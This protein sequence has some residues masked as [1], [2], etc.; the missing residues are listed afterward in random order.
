MKPCE[1]RKKPLNLVGWLGWILITAA[2]IC[3]HAG[4]IECDDP[5]QGALRAILSGTGDS[6]PVLLDLPLDHTSVTA[7]VTGFLARVDVTQLFT[8]NRNET[9]EAVYVFP[10]PDMAAVDA[11]TMIIGDQTIRGI[12]KKRDEAQALYEQAR[13]DGRT[14][15][16]LTQ[17]RPNIFTQAV[18]NILPGDRIEVRISYVQDLQY[19]HGE[20]EFNF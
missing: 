3:G 1:T 9:L 16:L 15:A 19:D 14:A 17:E 18:A 5:G 13:V 8:N 12:I 6:D 2:L 4:A 7:R 10:L 11:M 20:Y